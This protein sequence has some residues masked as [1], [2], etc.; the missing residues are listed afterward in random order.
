MKS[1]F[2]ILLG[3]CINQIDDL[4]KYYLSQYDYITRDIRK[5]MKKYKYGLSLYY[6]FRRQLEP[7]Q[8]FPSSAG[9][10]NLIAD[11]LEDF[12]ICN[13]EDENRRK[14][15]YRLKDNFSVGK[16]YERNPNK[17]RAGALCLIEQ[18]DI[19]SESV[20]IM[21]MIKY[22][23][24]IARMYRYLIE[25]FP[26]AYLSDKSI[27][28]S[29]LLNINSSI[30]EIKEKFVAKEIEEFMR[31][32]ISEWYD[33]F[34]KKQKANFLLEDNLFEKFKEVY[35]RRNLVVHNQGLVNDIYL[36]NIVTS[37]AKQGEKL[38]IDKKY[39]ENAFLTT[40]LMILDTFCG[41]I[42]IEDD[43]SELILWLTEYAYLCLS[44]KRWVQAKYI[45][46]LILQNDSLS[47]ADR[48]IA[49]INYWICIK[50]TEGSS[51]I[52]E[53]VNALD[54][55]AMQLQFAAAKAAL[56]DRHQEV[57]E[58]L[59]TCIEK[60][61]I[62]AYYIKIW[63]LFNEFRESSE[64][65]DFLNRHHDD[66]DLAEYEDIEDNERIIP[67]DDEKIAEGV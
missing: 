7:D 22:E 37:N 54:V 32:P 64:Y 29:E 63:P 49:K 57:S 33:S 50:N 21:L 14:I 10:D 66:F 44:E 6:F 41:L 42:K 36:N 3:N 19:L 62:P 4:E 65:A 8:T 43:K 20:L 11:M 9:A 18:P 2:T 40:R 48:L 15:M 59:D 26:Q 28:Y 61:E 27:K 55:S 30:D 16:E 39:L 46:M 5:N 38:K 17:A 52:E 35:Y 23:D 1:Y 24:S 51:A 13:D 56:L 58:I 53:D 12:Q 31:R 67:S 34:K 45:Y 25:K 47:T 60:K